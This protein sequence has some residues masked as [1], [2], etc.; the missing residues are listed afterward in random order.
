MEKIKNFF[1]PQ[2]LC[3]AG[4]SSKEKS[5]GYEI[6]K[7]IKEYGYKGKIYPVNPKAETILGYKCYRSI[8]EIEYP[9][10]LAVIVVIMFCVI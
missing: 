2:T 10:D 6:L 1:Y 8:E 5:I 4:A 3:I 9:I 7:N